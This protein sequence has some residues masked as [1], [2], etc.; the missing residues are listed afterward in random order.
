MGSMKATKLSYDVPLE[1]QR[2]LHMQ[3]RLIQK[4]IIKQARERE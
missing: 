4:K 1:L 3:F 2:V